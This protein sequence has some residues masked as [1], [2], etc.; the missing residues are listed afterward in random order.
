MPKKGP[1]MESQPSAFL[2]VKPRA[3]QVRTALAKDLGLVNGF[4]AFP[5]RIRVSAS[6]TVS[7]INLN[8]SSASLI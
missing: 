4:P 8:V 6:S 7:R 5:L 3:S 2:S 1:S